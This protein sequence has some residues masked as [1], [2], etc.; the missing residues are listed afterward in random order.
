MI[1]TAKIKYLRIS[2]RK[3]RM[4]L[5]LIKGKRVSEALSILENTNKK[6]ARYVYKAL[7]SAQ[8]NAKRF[9]NVNEESLYISSAYAD[10][11]PMLKRFRARP[12]G[13][14]SPIRKRTAHLFIGLDQV[15][16]KPKQEVEKTKKAK[17]VKKTVGAASRRRNSRPEAAPTTRRKKTTKG[18]KRGAK[19]T[20]V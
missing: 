14:A 9:P 15:E 13:M 17:K 10:G 4:V 16:V 19:S 7:H 20:S 1:A 11:G 2:P 8:S 5:P 3:L 12:M 18:E 6:A